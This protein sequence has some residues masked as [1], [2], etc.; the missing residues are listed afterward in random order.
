MIKVYTTEICPKCKILKV[1][2][3]GK[4]VEYEE[5]LD[6]NEMSGLGIRT[7][8]V[9]MIDGELMNFG[10]AIKWVNNYGK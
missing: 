4:N 6:V 8:P 1:K 3:A 7:V 5:I 10:E 2:L 9:M